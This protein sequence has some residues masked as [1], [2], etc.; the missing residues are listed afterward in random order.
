[1]SQEKKDAQRE[2]ERLSKNAKHCTKAQDECAKFRKTM[3]EC[4]KRLRQ[5]E[6]YKQGAKCKKID[7]DLKQ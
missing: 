5:T 6:T 1:M 3:R 2:K 7:S 4:V